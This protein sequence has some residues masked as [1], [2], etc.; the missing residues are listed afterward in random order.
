MLVTFRVSP[1]NRSMLSQIGRFY[2]SIEVQYYI[3]LL[4]SS[5]LYLIR[6]KSVKM[7][8]YCVTENWCVGRIPRALYTNLKLRAKLSGVKVACTVT[9]LLFQREKTRAAL[10]A[11]PTMSGELLLFETMY[12]AK[13]RS[14]SSTG[15]Y[16]SILTMHVISKK[17]YLIDD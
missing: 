11:R 13:E 14:S 15:S 9:S 7:L 8:S 12:D 3:W 4:Q 17:Y 2:R 10:K 6:V 1:N 16:K 5:C